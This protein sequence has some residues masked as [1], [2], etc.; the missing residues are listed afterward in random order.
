MSIFV[1]A[2]PHARIEPNIL[3]FGTPVVLLSSMNE[4][5]TPNLAPMSSAFWLGWRGMLGL[6]SRAKTAHNLIRTRECVLNLPSDALATA[7]DRLA[8]TTGAHPVPDR[9]WEGGYRYVPDKF[10]RAGL[11]ATPSETVAPPRVAECPV[12]M[13][14]VVEAVHPVGDDGGT[15]AFEVRVQ[16]VWVHEEIRMAGTV[17]RI[18]PDAWRPLI[19]S[20]QKFYGLGAQVH[21]STLA[22]IPEHLYRG[23]DLERARAL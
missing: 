1:D 5:G 22:S 11:T 16:R 3:Y 14:A 19:M 18:D 6:G 23:K 7:V 13:E 9:K 2:D 21:P 10:Q 8:L 12:S 20:F 17:D 4:D 15:L